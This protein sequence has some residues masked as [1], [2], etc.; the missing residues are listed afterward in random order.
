VELLLGSLARGAVVLALAFLAE[1]GLRRASAGLRHALWVTAFG[2]LL[3]L[4]LAP[5]L[6]PRI[7]VPLAFEPGVGPPVARAADSSG[8]TTSLPVFAPLAGSGGLALAEL[9]LGAW[10]LGAALLAGLHL[11]RR[12]VLAGWVRHAEPLD[13]PGEWRIAARVLASERTPVPLAL[14]FPRR[15]IL[16]P[17]AARSWPPERLRAVLRHESAHLARRDDVVLALAELARAL[18]WP[19][20]LAWLALRRL[21]RWREVSCDDHVLARGERPSEYARHLLALAGAAPR[22]PAGRLAPALAGEPE[23]G[24]RVRALLDGRVSHALLRPRAAAAVACVAVL[25]VAPLAGLHAVP[26]S[27]DALA[28]ARELVELARRP[29]LDPASLERLRAALGDG[30][31]VDPVELGSVNTG[32]RQGSLPETS[33]GKEAAR[34]L[35]AHPGEA[36][37]LL[38]DALGD[39]RWPA[40][41]NAIWALGCSGARA[42]AADIA[43]RLRD[44]PEERVRRIAAWALGEMRARSERVALEQALADPAPPVR[45]QAAHSLG[46]LGDGRAWPELVQA[47]RDPVASVRERAAHGLGDLAARDSEPALR[48]ALAEEVDAGARS[49]VAWALREV[50]GE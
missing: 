11:L 46:D 42:A 25:L 14:G 10:L 6:A 36:F 30:R 37:E 21:V 2:A 40:R 24:R 33:V 23:V 28:R 47:L 27:A 8:G 34:V 43:R 17:A 31:R 32:P 22:G 50:G 15:A 29:A 18:H 5:L 41:E 38:L 39:E 3:A 16:L 26:R 44:D 49:M 9:L 13:I 45:A 20:P 48:A 7:E 4:P 19:D 12:A 35:N 1:L